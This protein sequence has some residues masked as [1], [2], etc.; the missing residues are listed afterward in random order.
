MKITGEQL[1]AGKPYRIAFLVLVL[2]ALFFLFWGIFISLLY[3]R[4]SFGVIHVL[5]GG[6]PSVFAAI[7][8]Y[9]KGYGKGS[10]VLYYVIFCL[11]LWILAVSLLT[12][13]PFSIISALATLKYIGNY[14][15]EPL[16][17]AFRIAPFFWGVFVI[18]GFLLYIVFLRK[19][20]CEQQ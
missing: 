8:C 6:L 18:V 16:D 9:M 10:K 14:G 20:T 3:S 2:L 19:S 1:P 17:I 11:G 5:M 7:L 13:V 4:A 15:L 12:A